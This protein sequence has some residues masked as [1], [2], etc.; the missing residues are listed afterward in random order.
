MDVKDILDKGTLGTK[1]WDHIRK[2]GLPRYQ[3]T[4]L[5]G[6]T[7][8]RF[9]AWSHELNL[10]NGI[11]FTLAMLWLRA[12]GIEGEVDLQT[13]WVEEFGGSNPK[14]LERLQQRYFEPLGARLTKTLLGRKEHNGRVE[15]SHCTDDEEFYVLY[16]VPGQGAE[17]GGLSPEKGGLGVLL[18]PQAAALWG[19]ESGSW[20]TQEH[21]EE[22]EL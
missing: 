7:R 19:V 20:I 21:Q 6:R 3:W 14:N 22:D 10:T 16:P 9:L 4:F 11:C 13:D 12:F 5:E 1:L 8:L 15:R 18:Q 17:R 2:K